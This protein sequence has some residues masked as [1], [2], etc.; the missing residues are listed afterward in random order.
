MSDILKAREVREAA[1]ILLRL[2]AMKVITRDK[3]P[4]E[5]LLKLAETVNKL[6]QEIM[7]EHDIE[8]VRYWF[9][10]ES[11]GYFATKPFEELGDSFDAGLC[12]EI[13]RAEYLN[14]M[15]L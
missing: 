15:S 11:D 13:T 7:L 10:G 3:R 6:E 2:W 8:G 5:V 12:V 4:H 14:K 9:H 1:T